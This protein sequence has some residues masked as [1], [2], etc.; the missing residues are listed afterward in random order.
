[1][2]VVAKSFGELIAKLEAESSQKPPQGAGARD[3]PNGRGGAEIAR[4]GRF[5]EIKSIPT[6]LI[7]KAASFREIIAKF[8]PYHD[9]K[10]RFATAD[11]AASFTFKPGASAAH[12]KAIE[13]ARASAAEAA[14][15][16]RFGTDDADAMKEYIKK[17]SGDQQAKWTQDQKD[18]MQRYTGWVYQPINKHMRHQNEV[19]LPEDQR[20]LIKDL[21]NGLAKESLPDN[22]IVYRGLGKTASERILRQ[23]GIKDPSQAVGNGFTDRAFSSSSLD[24]EVAEGFASKNILMELKLPKGSKAVVTGDTSNIPRESEVI[25]QRGGSFKITGYRHDGNRSI[26]SAELVS[27][28]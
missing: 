3:G 13:R 9:E 6:G 28:D 18:A 4:K 10:G 14:K 15:W 19:D 22:L 8:N 5:N 16:K 1:M 23:M 12:D 26:W 7:W 21:Q 20:K 24:R 17:T 2:P 25:I 27:T 11:G